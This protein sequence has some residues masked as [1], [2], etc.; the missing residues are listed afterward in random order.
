MIYGNNGATSTPV[1]LYGEVADNFLES[2]GVSIFDDGDI[3]IGESVYDTE[4]ACDI[5][6]ESGIVLCEDCIVLE[7]KQAEE[8][9][10]RKAK[11][12]ADRDSV[13]NK[14][15]LRRY[16]SP[17][18]NW[19]DNYGNKYTKS[20]T[21]KKLVKAGLNGDDAALDKWATR[22][23]DDQ[24]RMSKA[25]FIGNKDYYSGKR[26][27]NEEENARAND[28]V[29]RHM[30]RHPKQYKESTIFSDIEII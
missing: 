23:T 28:A 26:K 15:A 10:A 8:Y 21:T 17:A 14:Q 9:K 25:S 3:A 4:T 1:R 5:L 20:P 16:P 27:M 19:E 12:K 6:E 29:N 11:E 18:N 7:G 30:R 22:Y 2:V 24:R 13:L